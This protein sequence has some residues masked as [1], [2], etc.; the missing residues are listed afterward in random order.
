MLPEKPGTSQSIF[1]LDPR[2]ACINDQ[3]NHHDTRGLN[4]EEDFELQ[5]FRRSQI[6]WQLRSFDRLR[7]SHWI[8]GH[9]MKP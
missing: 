2:L 8:R 5:D 1:S 3:I 4:K 9:L 7:L 6:T